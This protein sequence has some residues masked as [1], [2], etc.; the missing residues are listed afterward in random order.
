MNAALA[1]ILAAYAFSSA[2][3]LRPLAGGL[4]NQTFLVEEAGRRA[5]L[6]RVH[7]VFQ[8]SVHLD[9][10]VIT[11]H[12]ARKG[13]ATPR[14]LETSAG[15]LWTTDAAGAVWRMLTW[16]DG[17]TL[18]TVQHPE[19]ARS[20]GQ[21]VARFHHALSD[22]Q[23][24][25]HFSRPGVHDTPAHIEH[26]RLA[27]AAF[28]SHPQYDAIAPIAALIARSADELEP[29]P[30]LPKRLVHGDLKI[31]NVLFNQTHD[32][33]LALV[34][35]DT[36]ASLTIPVEMGDAFRSWCNPA[37]EDAVRVTFRADLFAAGIEGYASGARTLLTVDERAALVPAVETIAL[38]LASRFCADA[39]HESYFGWNP[40]KFASRSEH[41]L[42]RAQSQ[43]ALAQSVKQQRSALEAIVRRH[44]GG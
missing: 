16:L 3:T 21:L 40:E 34:D 22:L 36:L 20:A 6:Q 19:T 1:P 29:L 43:L 24:T 35:L 27:L 10:D 15:T 30:Q 26:M 41:N 44:F 14:L 25:F 39:L 31:S 18:T 7:P 2:S 42:A 11:A 37:G 23:H 38:E 12:L 4:I 8:P 13:L 28:S 33:A 32:R 5:V 17:H 9:I